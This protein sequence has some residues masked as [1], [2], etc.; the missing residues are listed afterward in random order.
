MP[1]VFTRS[2]YQYDK[3]TNE[4]Y[5][6]FFHLNYLTIPGLGNICIKNL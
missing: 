6:Q 1:F 5:E 4:K 3:R 2:K